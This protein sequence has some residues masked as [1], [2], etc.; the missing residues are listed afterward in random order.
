MSC[1][2]CKHKRLIYFVGVNMIIGRKDEQKLLERIY[3]SKQSEF[4]TVFGRRRVGK[5]FLIRE[6][7]VTKDCVFFHATGMK[8]GNMPK[9]LKKF[10][11]SI[12]ET[13]FDATTI[14]TPENWGDAFSVL[15]KQ[16][17]KTNKK[18]IIFL[19]ELPWMATR[20]SDLLQEIDYYWNH[21]WS[22]KNNIVLIVCGSSASWLIKKII[23]N[24]GGLHNRTT[25]KIRLLPFSLL[26]TKK[27]LQSRNI[28]L[29]DKHIL[30]IYMVLGGIPYYLRY[31]EPGLTAQENIQK[32]IFDT[33]ASLKGEFNILF[34]S[35]FDNADAYIELIRVIAQKKEGMKRGE[36]DAMTKLSTNGG[37]LSKRLDDLCAVGFVEEYIPW[38]RS[39]GEY[40]KLIDE[41][42]LFHMHW[43]YQQKNKKFSQNYWINQSQKP[44][45]YSWPGYAFESL[46]I[47]HVDNIIQALKI[48]AASTIGA[49][50][51]MPRKHLETGAQ[52]DLVIDRTDNAITVCEIKYTDKAFV[53]DKRYADTLKKKIEIFKNVTKTTKQIF[54]VMI[55]SDGLKKN[56][57]ANEL[58]ANHITLDD[59]FA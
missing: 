4:V 12:S 36:L 42:C 21:H 41:F 13:F 55:C 30:S 58:I 47:K 57:Y 6:F 24:K 11:E 5:T 49:W 1:L 9:Q 23:Y 31:V 54:M 20:K 10:A 39:K 40:Y 2:Y 43:V 50:R 7:Y 37:T 48:N 18:T 28:N 59:L 45:Y 32:I 52:I 15:H 38:G 33:N 56:S 16:I 17:S 25:C 19:D 3:T 27:Y 22:M 46:C 51:Y 29:N 34:D 35:L 8:D 26:E 53:I 44:A 14:E